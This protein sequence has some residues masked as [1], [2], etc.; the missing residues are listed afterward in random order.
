[1]IKSLFMLQ[2]KDPEFRRVNQ[3]RL[4]KEQTKNQVKLFKDRPTDR[5][6]KPIGVS[7][8]LTIKVTLIDCFSWFHCCCRQQLAKSKDY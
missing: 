5:T 4:P 2:T 1:M 3:T 6:L 7:L 8:W